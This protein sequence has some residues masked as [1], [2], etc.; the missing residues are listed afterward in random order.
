M[1]F[2]AASTKLASAPM[3]A[4][5]QQHLYE[6]SQAYIFLDANLAMCVYAGFCSTSIARRKYVHR[7]RASPRL[8]HNL[9]RNPYL[10]IHYFPESTRV[11]ILAITRAALYG[12]HLWSEQDGLSATL[13]ILLELLADD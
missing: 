1:T 8:C 10:W 3:Y 11:Q 13:A 6:L 2:L 4:S 9:R 12:R 5:F 7:R